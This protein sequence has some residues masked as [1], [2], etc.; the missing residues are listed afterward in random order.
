MPMGAAGGVAGGE[1]A[2]QGDCQHASVHRTVLLGS[3]GGL[4]TIRTVRPGG[5]PEVPGHAV[6]GRRT[7]PRTAETRTSSGSGGGLEGHGD[8]AEASEALGELGVGGAR[9]EEVDHGRRR[10]PA[11]APARGPG[12]AR[13]R[14]ASPR[15]AASRSLAD[16]TAATWAP[17]CGAGAEAAISCRL[18]SAGSAAFG[19]ASGRAA[20][21]SRPDTGRR[22][23]H[24]RAGWGSGGWRGRGRRGGGCGDAVGGAPALR[25]P[26]PAGGAAGAGL[27]GCALSLVASRDWSARAPIFFCS[28][29]PDSEAARRRSSSLGSAFFVF[30]TSPPAPWRPSAARPADWD[31]FAPTTGEGC[32]AGAPAA[33]RSRRGRDA[34]R[35]AAARCG[36]PG[37]A[38]RSRRRRGWHPGLPRRRRGRRAGRAAG[39]STAARARPT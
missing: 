34:A 10:P 36:A 3:P 14:S 31:S 22:L 16:R 29:S 33:R 25:A 11:G 18:L 17:P 2:Q 32:W 21:S 19:R 24:R 38:R 6:S 1:E 8:L 30:P 13:T 20:G 27:A 39:P 15:R 37:Q 12:P 23:R 5:G 35:S 9:N 7:G 4:L 26:S 28:R